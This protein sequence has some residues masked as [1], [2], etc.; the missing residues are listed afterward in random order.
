MTHSVLVLPVPELDPVVRPRLERRSPHNMPVDGDDAAAHVTLLGPFAELDGIDDGLLSELASFFAD[1]TPFT[2]QLTGINAFPGGQVYLSPEPAGIFRQLTHELWRRF[3]EFP[4]Y[5]G[6]FDDVVPHLSIP[7]PEGEALDGLRF[8]LHPRLPITA[9]AR[10]AALW[11]YEP[12]GCRTIAT[13]TFG[14]TAA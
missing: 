3:P 13:F 5:G 12:E 1:I 8:E 7:M 4:P 2:F 6:D 9:H 14:T 10:E 11:W